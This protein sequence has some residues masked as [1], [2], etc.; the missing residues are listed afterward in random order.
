VGTRSTMGD[1][2]QIIAGKYR[3]QERLGEGGMGRVDAAVNIYS[4]QRVALKR[5]FVA[6]PQGHAQ[7]PASPPE[8]PAPERRALMERQLKESKALAQLDHPYIVRLLDCGPTGSAETGELYIAME[9]VEGDSLRSLIRQAK[10]DGQLLK[11][12]LVLKIAAEVAE[13]MDFAHIKKVYHRDLKPENIIV[14]SAGHAKVVDFGLAKTSAVGPLQLP[15][16]SVDHR[17]S[18]EKVVGTARYMAPEQ[19]RGLEIDERTDIY[20]LGVTMYEGISLRT[21]YDRNEDGN[22][23]AAELMGHHLF[24][25]ATPVQVH[26][27]TCPERV[28]R[29]ISRCLA[30]QPADRYPHMGSLARALR[31][32][33]DLIRAELAEISQGEDARGVGAPSEEQ[34]QEPAPREARMTEPMPEHFRPGASLPF[35]PFAPATEPT[36]PREVRVTEPMAEPV[37]PPRSALPFT[38]AVPEPHDVT[39]S[40]TPPPSATDT[41][42]DESTLSRSALPP[43]P[44]GSADVRGDS[45][46]PP[47]SEPDDEVTIKRSGTTPASPAAGPTTDAP[48]DP[49]E[50]RDGGSPSVPSF[51]FEPTPSGSKKGPAMRESPFQV[52]LPPPPLRRRTRAAYAG[53]ILV[54]FSMAVAAMLVVMKVYDPSGDERRAK[55][56]ERPRVPP[57]APAAPAPAAA[58]A[59]A[60]GAPPEPE[61]PSVA[62]SATAR[63]IPVTTPMLATVSAVHAAG[64]AQHPMPE[65]P[66]APLAPASTAPAVMTTPPPALP[67]PAPPEPSASS[68][69]LFGV[70]Q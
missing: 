43:P 29:I 40:S 52:S 21:P 67:P 1:D 34:L 30:K 10:K 53:A 8:L 41:E 68:H 35:A 64:S 70:E 48:G 23:S 42:L 4:G 15:G 28:S 61:Q 47:A 24:A 65:R 3:L 2:E 45:A 66:R 36:P 17:T 55:P 18:P 19:V 44:S 20:A 69:R 39:L 16:D 54:G 50:S 56:E 37:S 7:G 32:E 60:V 25:E 6:P 27:P 51:T 12:E 63:A 33:L 49:Q 11:I 38:A 31:A 9:L 58:S 13:A 14:A 46:V 59:S 57:A 26:V 5:L 62:G 22:A